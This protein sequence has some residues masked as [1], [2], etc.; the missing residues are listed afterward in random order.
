MRLLGKP[1]KDITP[2]DIFYHI[3]NQVLESITL[4]YKRGLP[5]NSDNDKKEFLADISSFVN[6]S[7]GVIIYGIEEEKDEQ[8]RNTGIP[9]GVTGLGSINVDQEKQRLEA[10][11]REGLDPRLN[12]IDIQH[13]EINGKIILMIG[14]PRSLFA[15]HMVSYKKSGKFFYRTNSGKQQMDSREIKQAFLQTDQWEKETDN[16][17]RK[18]IMEVRSLNF[19]SNLQTDSSYFI[20]ILPLGFKNHY[21]DIKTHKDTLSSLIAPAYYS[22]WNYRFNLDGYLVFGHEETCDSYVQYFRNGGVEIYISPLII[23]EIKDGPLKLYGDD[24]E[25]I[26]IEYISKYLSFTPILEVAP[27]F[28]IYLTLMGLKSI[29]LRDSKFRYNSTYHFDKDE[30]L[31]PGVFF[32]DFNDNITTLMQPVLDMFWQS[33]GW[34][35]SP[36]FKNGIWSVGK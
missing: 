31:L 27:P 7:G 15:P 3:E 14:L 2:K 30:I 18:R 13:L 22:G 10:I 4:D 28:V 20:H 17:R 11:I 25:K 16:F 6:T 34:E 5:G 26:T 24:L 23:Q 32:E 29:S 12:N 33:A 19:I 35:G 8:G 9:K 21:I 36:N 1:L